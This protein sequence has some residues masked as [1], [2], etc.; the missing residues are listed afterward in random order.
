MSALVGLSEFGEDLPS[1]LYR[2]YDADGELLYVGITSNPRVRMNSHRAHAQW[3]ESCVRRTMEWYPS[4]PEALAAERKAISDENP[5]HNVVRPHLFT[6]RSEGSRLIDPRVE[7]PRSNDI[8]RPL[9]DARRS[10]RLT[11]TALS[12]QCAACGCTVSPESLARFE[13]GVQLPWPRVIPVLTDV[14]G[15]DV[16]RIYMRLKDERAA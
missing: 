7:V 13:C 14:L 3:W 11:L 12:R 10:A 15:I 8:T 16:A 5:R 2:C 9:Y 4:R 1:A 6:R